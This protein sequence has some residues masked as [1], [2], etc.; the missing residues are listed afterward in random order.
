ME[1]ALPQQLVQC[2]HGQSSQPVILRVKPTHGYAIEPQLK[3]EVTQPTQR[4]PLEY[5]AQETRE[6]ELEGPIYLLHKATL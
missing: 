6:T 3:H 2:S 5:L 1:S 4:T